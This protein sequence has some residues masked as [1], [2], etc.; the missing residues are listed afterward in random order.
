MEAMPFFKKPQMQLEAMHIYN[1]KKYDMKEKGA[2]GYADFHK[3]HNPKNH[4]ND[5]FSRTARDA[6]VH[7]HFLNA[8]TLENSNTIIDTTAPP[9]PPRAKKKGLTEKN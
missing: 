4:V 3:T 8:K 1:L 6:V 2:G 7:A 5:I 9:P